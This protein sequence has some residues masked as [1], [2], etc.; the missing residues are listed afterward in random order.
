MAR[1]RGWIIVYLCT[2]RITIYALPLTAILITAFG[3][4]SHLRVLASFRTHNPDSFLP[5]RHVYLLLAALCPVTDSRSHPISTAELRCTPSHGIVVELSPRYHAEKRSL[6]GA[7]LLIISTMSFFAFTLELS[8][9]VVADMSNEMSQQLR[10]MLAHT[11]GCAGPTYCL[12]QQAIGSQC[13][14]TGTGDHEA[15]LEGQRLVGGE[16][17]SGVF[18]VLD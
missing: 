18:A 6:R 10:M 7:Q 5:R 17:R 8:P 13:R 16:F 2:G 4:S 15:V 11:H 1:T 9:H 12:P 3:S 14:K